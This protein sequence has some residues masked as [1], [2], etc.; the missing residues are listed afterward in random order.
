MQE[1]P[2]IVECPVHTDEPSIFLGT[3]CWKMLLI[4]ESE[5]PKRYVIK[6]ASGSRSKYTQEAKQKQ[7]IIM[8]VFCVLQ[9]LSEE[10]VKRIHICR[11]AWLRDFLHMNVVWL[12]LKISSLF[13]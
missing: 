2:D 7:K 13:N 12:S 8:V 11:I 10:K 9:K 1:S 3:A 4:S 5:W 6:G